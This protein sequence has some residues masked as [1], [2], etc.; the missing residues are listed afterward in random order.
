M[1][2]EK[3]PDELLQKVT[4]LIDSESKYL[5]KVLYSCF[6]EDLIEE[7]ESRLSAVNTE[8]DKE[9]GIGNIEE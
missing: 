7:L 8:L 5:S 9:Q 6:L 3:K 1:A 2:D 4:D